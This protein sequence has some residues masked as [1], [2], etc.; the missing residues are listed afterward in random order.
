MRSLQSQ[1]AERRGYP[2]VI[3]APEGAYIPWAERMRHPRS[4]A[5]AKAMLLTRFSRLRNNKNQLENECFR[6]ACRPCFQ[7]ALRAGPA[8]LV[9]HRG[10]VKVSTFIS[11]KTLDSGIPGCVSCA[12]AY[13][14]AEFHLSSAGREPDYVPVLS[15]VKLTNERAWGDWKIARGRPTARGDDTV[16][17]DGDCVARR[18]L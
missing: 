14:G 13:E 5:S 12:S 4:M 16:A 1:W 17:V 3:A 7:R 11:H 15:S 9:H 6:V 2:T 10:H 8:W 18:V